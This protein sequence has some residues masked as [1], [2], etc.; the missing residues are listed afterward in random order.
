[1]KKLQKSGSFLR[2][3]LAGIGVMACVTSSQAAPYASCITNLGGGVIQ[4]D[5]NEGGA[6]VYV[7]FGDG[8]SNVLGVLPAGFTNFTLPG[9]NTQY[10]II[11]AKT[12]TG[13]P[14]KISVDSGTN[15]TIWNNGM[16]LRAVDVNKNPTNAYAFG[17]VYAGMTGGATAGTISRQWGIY[18][19]T[20]DLNQNA[21]FGGTNTN[22]IS[23]V[24]AANT[25]L[26]WGPAFN[27]GNGGFGSGPYRVR[28]M[29]DGTVW[30]TDA[31]DAGAMAWQFGPNFE[32]TNQVFGVIG[33][34]AGQAANIHGNILEIESTGSIAAGNLVVWTADNSMLFRAALPKPT[35]ATPVSLT[36]MVRRKP[37]PAMPAK[38]IVMTSAPVRF[39]GQT[40][41]SPPLLWA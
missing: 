2:G 14:F 21:F 12:G 38:F 40:L 7:V 5:M 29:P 6:N 22:A 10:G 37:S 18:G 19:I 39:L 17:R 28:V 41:R 9:T 34:L 35:W 8:T 24:S 20:A 16:T 23:F 36:F 11:C 1:M 33:R 15:Y 32:Y 4:F 3:L 27:T 26:P 31:T 25:N 13:A 30:A